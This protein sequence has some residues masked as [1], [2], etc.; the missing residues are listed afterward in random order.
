MKDRYWHMPT[1]AWAARQ[2]LPRSRA[3]GRDLH[4]VYTQ[5][6]E[7]TFLKPDAT[8]P[9]RHRQISPQPRPSGRVHAPLQSAALHDVVGSLGRVD[10]PGEG[11]GHLVTVLAWS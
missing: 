3:T 6:D 10:Y 5:L 7:Y 1:S 4:L 11:D 8:P 9:W 2:A